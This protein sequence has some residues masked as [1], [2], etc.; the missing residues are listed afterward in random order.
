MTVIIT[1]AGYTIPVVIRYHRT[2]VYHIK[3]YAATD[4]VLY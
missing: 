3:Q 2:S 4:A 1:V